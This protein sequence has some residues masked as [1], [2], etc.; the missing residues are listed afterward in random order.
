MCKKHIS[1]MTPCYNEEANILN[2]YRAVKEQFDKLPQYTYEHIFIDNFSTDRS[3]EILRE[4][5]GQDK[6]VKVILNAR[7]FGPNRSGSYGMLQATGD[8]LICIVCDLQDPP[9]MIPKFLEKWEEGYK[10]VLGQKMKS[11]ESPIMFQ[12]RKLYYR[13]INWLSETPQY[14]GVTGYGLF[15]KDFLDTM[16]WMDDPDPY[17]RGLVPD[18]GYK[19][20]LL[21]YTQNK[22]EYGKSSYNFNRY[23]DFAITGVTHV[24]KKPLRIAT[25]LG[26]VMSGISF[27]VGIIYLILKLVNWN[28][29]SMGTAPI[30]IGMFLLA[31]V[32]LA[33]IGV[34]GEY[35]G[36]IL[37]RVTKRPMVVEEERIN[38]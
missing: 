2:L 15:D 18:L 9:S 6:N 32:Q 30:L 17:I 19:T 29:F 33:F 12:V 31:S 4:L 1:V 35:I 25:M 37:T 13:I 28:S 26:M 14:E 20:Y 8:A 36:A 23:F 22:R 11:K 24:S 7:N 21:E 27:L 3:R 34:I 16:R 5:A 10:V 38:F